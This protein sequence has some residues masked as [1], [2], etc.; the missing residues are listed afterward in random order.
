MD[1]YTYDVAPARPDHDVSDF[2]APVPALDFFQRVVRSRAACPEPHVGRSR[3]SC[4]QSRR[5][6]RSRAACPATHVLLVTSQLSM[7]TSQHPR[8]VHSHS[9]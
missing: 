5:S 7:V 9:C 8:A 1:L 4:Q 2:T 3:H 6:T